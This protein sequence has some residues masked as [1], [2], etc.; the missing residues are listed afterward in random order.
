[1]EAEKKLAEWLRP[2]MPRKGRRNVLPLLW[3]ALA[4]LRPGLLLGALAAALLAGLLA[5]RLTMPL[6]STFCAVPLPL[7]LLYFRYYWRDDPRVRELERTFRF[8]FH[9][10][11]FA[12]FAVMAGCAAAALAVLCLT[13]WGCGTASIL[14]LALC[15]ASSAALL[16]GA[17]LLLSLREKAEGLCLTAGALW[18]GVCAPMVG[19]PRMEQ[20]LGALPLWGWLLPLG[21]G[22]VMTAVGLKGGR[23]GTV[24]G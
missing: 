19:I 17:L 24:A 5:A 21:L 10:M 1:M 12:R 3:L 14:S 11:C 15:G 16:G 18:M 20:R 8:S 4:E 2:S 13:A 23:H 6:V 22:L 9:Q 7:F